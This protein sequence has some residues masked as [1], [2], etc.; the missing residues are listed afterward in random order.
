MRGAQRGLTIIELMIVVAIIGIL[1][2]V[3]LPAVR[4]YIVRENVREAVDLANPA[5]AALGI[6]CSKGELAGADNLSLGLAPGPTYSGEYT[7]N[8]AAVGH[9]STAGTVTVTL[10]SIAGVIDDGGQI[11]YSGACGADG[12]QWSITGDVPPKYLPEN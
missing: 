9:D 11:V 1:A 6:A 3:A 7:R 4:D 10:R 12:M 5:R 2:S 8:V